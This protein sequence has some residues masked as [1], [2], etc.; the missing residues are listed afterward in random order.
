MAPKRWSWEDYGSLVGQFFGF[1]KPETKKE[2]KKSNSE[3]RVTPT[4]PVRQGGGPLQLANSRVQRPAWA[5]YHSTSC[6]KGTVADYII[7]DYMIWYDMIWYD[8]IWYYIILYCIVL[9]YIILYYI[10]LYYIILYYIRLCYIILYYIILYYSIL[11]SMRVYARMLDH[12][13]ICVCAS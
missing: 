9:Y 3:F 1:R 6:R 12:T 4:N 11:Y 5:L 10:V 2:G 13:C 8:M 7:L